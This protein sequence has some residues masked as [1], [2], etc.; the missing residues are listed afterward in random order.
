MLASR[1]RRCSAG[2]LTA[3]IRPSRALSNSV[4]EPTSVGIWHSADNIASATAAL[5][6]RLVVS[7]MIVSRRWP[8]DQVHRRIGHR[9][10]RAARRERVIDHLDSLGQQRTN[11]RIA[12][13]FCR[14]RADRKAAARAILAAE[15]AGQSLAIQAPQHLAQR[16]IVGE[17]F[18][19]RDVAEFPVAPERGEVELALVTERAIEARPIHAGRCAQIVERGRGIAGAPEAFGGAL[20]RDLGIVGAR[21]PA[22]P[23]FRSLWLFLYHFARNSLTR[24]TSSE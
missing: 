7:V 23:P 6:Q 9:L 15:I 11:F 13:R 16:P 10:Q 24:E 12:D 20:Q 1:I 21:P 22:R 18:F 4:S 17:R 2:T 14:R 5:G 19:H 3:R 8:A